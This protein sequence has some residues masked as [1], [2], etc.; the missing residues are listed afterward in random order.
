MQEYDKNDKDCKNI[1]KNEI[2]NKE[3]V[4]RSS[5]GPCNYSRCALSKRCR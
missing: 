5:D 2:F 4:E 3:T 1:G